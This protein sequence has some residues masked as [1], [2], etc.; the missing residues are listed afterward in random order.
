MPF[1]HY[2]IISARDL[3]ADDILAIF[4]RSHEYLSFLRSS[5]RKRHDLNGV[6]V[7]L[8]FF[9]N[10]TRTRVSFEL[11]AKR[12]SAEVTVFQ[13]ASS[14]VA[15]GETL[16]DTVLNIETMKVDILVMR[17]HHS[18]AHEFLALRK[19][20]VQS[21]LVNAGAGQHE[22]PTQGL[23]DAFTLFQ[24]FG[25]PTS[26]LR[27]MR[28]C[29]V[30]DILHSRVARSSI[31]IF[32][33]LGAEVAVCGP[34][35]LMPNLEAFGVRIFS[36]IDEAVEWADALN[37]LRIQHERMQVGLIPSLREYVQ[38]FGVKHYHIQRKPSLAILHPGPI[39]RGIELEAEVADAAQS[40]ILSQVERG[41]AVRMAVLALLAE[42]RKSSM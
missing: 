42:A 22:H 25:S 16:L 39:N 24:K 14:S 34:G 30:G 41:V 28:Y 4:D 20:R 29:L 37:V 7:V 2:H 31:P 8:A 27:G 40:L 11:A 19:G 23:L 17:H 10:S 26:M 35:T 21:S 13:A 5:D 33:T 15:K 6:S 3:S 38:Y 36:H 9:E 32:Q 12:L 18:G 1:S